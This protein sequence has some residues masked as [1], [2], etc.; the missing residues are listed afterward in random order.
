MIQQEQGHLSQARRH[1]ETTLRL[2][3]EFVLAHFCLGILTEQGGKPAAAH[4]HFRKAIRLLRRMD[5][6]AIV[7]ESE[8]IPAA[9]L[10]EIIQE[11]EEVF[12][13]S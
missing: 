13:V 11:Q 6:E 2:D 8:G 1:L 4:R 5:P 3:R 9:R 7:P 10:I 12:G